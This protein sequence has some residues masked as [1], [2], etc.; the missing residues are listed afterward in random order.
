MAAAAAAALAIALVP[1]PSQASGK[2]VMTRKKEKI[3]HML[4]AAQGH[5]AQYI[6]RALQG[7]LR[8]GLAEQT[9]LVALAHAMVLTPPTT[10]GSSSSA[11]CHKPGGCAAEAAAAVLLE[12]ALKARLAEAE[13]II[14]CVFCEMPS[15]QARAMRE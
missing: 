1:P 15:Y 6:V 2:D 14:K 12:E 3:K 11:A 4:V 9:V 10:R 8:I 7:K 13:A 5:D